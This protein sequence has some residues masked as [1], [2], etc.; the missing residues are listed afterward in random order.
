MAAAMTRAYS[1]GWRADVELGAGQ[2]AIRRQLVAAVAHPSRTWHEAPRI[3]ELGRSPGTAHRTLRR[4]AALGV[5]ALQ[6]T[7]GR[8]GRVRFT[9]GVHYWRRSP[10]RRGMLARFTASRP[11]AEGQL[12]LGLAELVDERIHRPGSPVGGADGLGSAPPAP[13]ATF[14]ELLSRAGFVAPW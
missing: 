13:G 5:V 12:G 2:D 14:G 9:F 8:N 10:I 4:L 1:R 11:P 3:R 7:L 6:S